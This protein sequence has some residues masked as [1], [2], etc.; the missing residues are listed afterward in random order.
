M[1][2]LPKLSDV[3]SWLRPDLQTVAEQY[4]ARFKAWAET[5]GGSGTPGPQGETGPAG[6]PGPAGPAGPPGASASSGFFSL[7]TRS[8]S[9]T[10]SI[11]NSDCVVEA[12]TAGITLTL[13]DVAGLLT[14]FTVFIK[15]TGNSSIRLEPFGSETIDDEDWQDVEPYNTAMVHLNAAKNWII[16]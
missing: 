2:T 10:G 4:D 8:V 6:P 15:N 13:P 5:G 12:T 11:L 14:G 16:L 1:A 3:T 7:A 9:T